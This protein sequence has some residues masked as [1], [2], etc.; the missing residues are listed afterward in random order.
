MF[1]CLQRVFNSASI[2]FKLAGRAD[3]HIALETRRPDGGPA[4]CRTEGW[5]EEQRPAA[6]SA[7]DI[8][9]MTAAT[10]WQIAWPTVARVVNTTPYGATPECGSSTEPLASSPSGIIIEPS[11]NGFREHAEYGRATYRCGAGA[12]LG[13]GNRLGVQCNGSVWIA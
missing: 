8:A 3:G 9:D 4:I 6:L 5:L 11:T 1:N 13:G 10:P 12:A 2:A 7:W